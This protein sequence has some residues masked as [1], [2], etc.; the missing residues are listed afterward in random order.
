[1]TKPRIVKEASSFIKLSFYIYCVS[2]VYKNYY[3]ELYH[4][5]FVM[6]NNPFFVLFA[7]NTKLGAHDN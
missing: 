3:S 1:M 7:A 4:F 6:S 2:K 5:N